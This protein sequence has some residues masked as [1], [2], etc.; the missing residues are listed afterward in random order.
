MLSRR[1]ATVAL[2]VVVAAAWIA[3]ITVTVAHQD[4]PGAASPPELRAELAA[5]LSGRDADALAG[6]FD[7]PGSGSDDLAKDY[8]NVLKDG[9]ARDISVQLAPDERSPTAAIVRG[10]A[11]AGEPFSYRLAVT[12]AKG[13]WTVAFTP[14]IP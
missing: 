12:T 2:A 5:A 7:V 11:G 9:N 13:R 1:N 10:K 14:P 3:S 4:P 6:L 8:V